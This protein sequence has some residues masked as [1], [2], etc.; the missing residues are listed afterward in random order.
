MFLIMTGR[1]WPKLRI[2]H[3]HQI[4]TGRVTE[5][6]NVATDIHIGSPAALVTCGQL[7]QPLATASDRHVVHHRRHLLAGTHPVGCQDSHRTDLLLGA[8]CLF[9]GREPHPEPIP[10][11]GEQRTAAHHHLYN[12]RYGHR[13]V[14]PDRNLARGNPRRR[15]TCNAPSLTPVAASLKSAPRKSDIPC[16]T[17]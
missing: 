9:D 15:L 4:Q 12:Y 10:P 7:D 8:I 6:A 13:L 11:A 2:S 16:L 5:T 3:R 17:S 1:F 14:D